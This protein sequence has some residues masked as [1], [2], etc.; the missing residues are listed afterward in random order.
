MYSVSSSHNSVRISGVRREN[1]MNFCNLGQEYVALYI[2]RLIRLM[3]RCIISYA[4]GNLTCFALP[5]PSSR[6]V[7][8]GPTHPANRN[9]YQES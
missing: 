1:R 9:E 8:L 7:A 4:E 3:V 6:T 2:R 5:H